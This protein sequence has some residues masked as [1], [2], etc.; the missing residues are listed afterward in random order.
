MIADKGDELEVIGESEPYKEGHVD[1][2][3][4]ISMFQT[5]IPSPNNYPESFCAYVKLYH[6]LKSLGWRKKN[7]SESEGTEEANSV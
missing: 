4:F 1:Y 6:H 7:E 3:E 5:K 2:E